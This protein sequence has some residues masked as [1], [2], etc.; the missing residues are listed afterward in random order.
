MCSNP[1]PPSADHDH[2]PDLDRFKAY[3]D[4]SLFISA[5]L[6]VTVLV[7]WACAVLL[8]DL[9]VPKGRKG[10]TALL[11]VAGMAVS[12]IVSLLQYGQY[13]GAFNYL[14]AV[15]GFAVF[16]NVLFLGSGIVAVALAYDYVKRMGIERGEYYVLLMFSISGM[17][18]MAVAASRSS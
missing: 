13:T 10:I 18:L 3:N 9:W 16:L 2:I 14:V 1:G 6:P 7:F 12:M 4:S 5:I 8:I 11:A 15:D 17:M